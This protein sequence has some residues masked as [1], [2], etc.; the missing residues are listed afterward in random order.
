MC[1][2]TA[3]WLAG[4]LSLLPFARSGTLQFCGSTFGPLHVSCFRLL[5]R[6]ACFCVV[7]GRTAVEGDVRRTKLG[8][9]FV[10]FDCFGGDEVSIVAALLLD[11][12]L[13]FVGQ[14]ERVRERSRPSC[15]R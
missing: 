1:G 4:S 10:S 14:G 5:F 12:C 13:F 7:V 2:E 15:W 3:R 6:S 11:M 8:C 9:L